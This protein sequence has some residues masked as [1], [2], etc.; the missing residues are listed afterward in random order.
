MSRR[1]IFIIVGIIAA[2]TVM[3][4]VT[5][6]DLFSAAG[7]QARFL[8]DFDRNTV[9]RRSCYSMEAFVDASRWARLSES[10]Q[11][12]AAQALGA[13][14]AEQGSSGQMTILDGES[15]RKLGHWDGSA[16]Q[17]VPAPTP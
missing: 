5:L 3:V 14:C 17:R 16:F 4:Y 1:I 10:D 15:R 9:V 11:Q 12:R 8:R 13:Y 7:R 2:I 6:P